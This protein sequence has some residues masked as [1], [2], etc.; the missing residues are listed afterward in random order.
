MTNG[1]VS[2]IGLGLL[3]L[4]AGGAA[5]AP[6][7]PAEVHRDLIYMSPG[8][9]DLHLDVYVHPRARTSPAPVLV[10]F[11]GGAWWKGSRPASWT[12]F[13]AYVEAGFSIVN[14]QYRLAGTGLAPAAVQDARCSIA[15]VS[16]NAQRF[17]FDAKRIVATGTSAG[18]HLALMAG[19]LKSDNDIDAAECPDVPRVAAIVD[20]YGPTDLDTWPAP[21]RGGGGFLQAP[22]SSIARWIGARPDAALMRKRM[23]PV[24][25]MRTDVPPLFIVHGDADP[26]VPLQES[27]NLKKRLDACGARSNLYIV[28]G[29]LHG[30][31]TS[32]Q[33][34]TIDS[35]VLQFLEK[36]GVIAHRGE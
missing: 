33:K 10:H 30:K 19:M 21:N 16:R 25:Y 1:W 12:G 35:T 27:L 28:P 23:S 36:Q 32:E 3:W 31:F 15:W 14:V 18:A 8:G 20:F 22:H 11:H 29:G 6:S 2:R 13:A 17:G 34:R 5:A 24:N 9:Q 7:E 26:V 4:V